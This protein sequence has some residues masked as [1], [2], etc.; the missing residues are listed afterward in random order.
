MSPFGTVGRE[1]LS[2]SSRLGETDGQDG[3]DAILGE[4]ARA[5]QG[6]LREKEEARPALDE[7]LA[8]QVRNHIYDR[9]D[10]ERYVAAAARYLRA[11][12]PCLRTEYDVIVVGAGIQ[13]AMFVYTAKK[14]A[15]C[16]KALVVEKSETICSTF[17]RLGDSLVLNSPTFS[18]V[19]LNSNVA[20][21]HFIQ[22]A[23][24]DE[25][26][27]R[28]FPTAKHL[29]ELAAMMLFHA[30]AD[31]AFDFSVSGVGKEGDQYSVSSG[32]RTVVAKSVVVANGMGEQR[33]DSFATDEPS[34]RV[35]DGDGFICACCEDETFLESIRNKTI[36]VVGAGDTANCVMEYLLPL[37][38]PNNQYDS[39]RTGSFAPSFVYWIGQGAESIQEF[40]FANKKRYC[41]SGGII[42]FFWD[43][44]APFDL[45]AG[46]WASTKARIRCVPGKLVSISD[47]GRALELTLEGERLNADIVVD[48]TGRFNALSRD[49]LQEEY[50]FVEGEIVFRGGRWDE[51]HDAFVASPRSV[52]ERRI[53]CKLKGERIFLI[54]CAGPLDEVVDDEEARDGSLKYQEDQQSL[55]NSKLSLEHTLPRSFAFA[56]RFPALLRD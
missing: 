41:H 52:G 2:G 45:P 26:A 16:L 31:V 8:K 35:V 56:T 10:R 34:A 7:P 5:A 27:E 40:Y 53:A 1:E 18:K 55:T 42:E 44:D 38:Y 19:G 30:D 32:G 54:G 17:C 20:P 28:P 37:T 36:A 39:F 46:S 25:L 48:C 12:R 21:G 9:R 22:L 51:S 4:A 14:R 23:D 13:A 15:P 50:E 33:T 11:K 49:L 3:G 47:E 43:G 6:F 24:F 29:Y